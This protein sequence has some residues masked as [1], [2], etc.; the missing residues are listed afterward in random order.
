[1]ESAHENIIAFGQRTLALQQQL[2]HLATIRGSYQ[3]QFVAGSRTIDDL[4]S[5]ERELYELE[6]QAINASYE[7]QR[8]PYRITADLGLLTHLIAGQL[9]ESLRP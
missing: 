9:E 4:I 5:I 6:V 3:K 7:Y 8:V 1:M 2:K